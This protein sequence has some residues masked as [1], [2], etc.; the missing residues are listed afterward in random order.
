MKKEKN[1]K[2]KP[3]Q[4]SPEEFLRRFENGESV[5]EYTDPESTIVVDGSTARINVDFPTWCISALDDES[6]RQGISRQALI[7]TWIVA[8]LDDLKAKNKKTI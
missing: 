7:K 2:Q 6:T 3:K 8:R 1:T 5:L 4:I